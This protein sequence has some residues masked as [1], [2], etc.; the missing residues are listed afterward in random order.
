MGGNPVL[1]DRFEVI[2]HLGSGGVGKVYLV[3]DREAG[4]ERR[5]LK[6]VDLPPGRE[7]LYG[8]IRGEFEL[9][10]RFD[11]PHLA[12]AYDI[13]RMGSSAFFTLE[14][15][16]GPTFLEAVARLDTG[17][18]LRLAVE[19]LQA[20]A[21]IHG[22]GY[23]HGD[24]KPQNIMVDSRGE[25]PRAKLLDFGLAESIMEAKSPLL[26]SSGTPAY[27][28]PEK[29]QGAPPDPR[30]DLYS[31]GVTLFEVL[32]GTLPFGGRTPAELI[33]KHRN[34]PAPKP[35]GVDPGLG[36]ELDRI[37]LR[38]MEKEPRRRFQNA[39]AVI[40]ALAP[41]GPGASGSVQVQGGKHLVMAAFVGRE[42]DLESLE[43]ALNPPGAGRPSLR[44]FA[45]IGDEGMGKSTL[46]KELALTARVRGHRV[47]EQ[48]CSTGAQG[49][50]EI[51]EGL[52]LPLKAG[53]EDLDPLLGTSL[54]AWSQGERRAEGPRNDWDPTV[55]AKSLAGLF[56]ATSVR[57][58][59]LVVLQNLHEV[60][61]RF[62]S[63]LARLAREESD[64]HWAVVVAAREKF[65]DPR[66]GQ[67]FEPL[68]AGKDVRVVRLEP[69][70]AEDVT[71]WVS[72]AFPGVDLPAET[73]E[74][75]IRWSGGS[76]LLV[77]EALLTGVEE[78]RFAAG[79][80]GWRYV[81]PP[82][83]KRFPAAGG[84]VERRLKS[85]SEGEKEVL[86]ALALDTGELR[87]EWM[88][89][90]L[91]VEGPEV[92]FPLLRRLARS[93]WV[94]EDRSSRS[95]VLPNDRVKR[96]LL[97]EMGRMAREAGHRRFGEIIEVAGGEE[98]D[99]G[100][101]LAGH[102]ARSGDGDRG[103]RWCIRAGEWLEKRGRY[104]AALLH[105]RAARRLALARE[106]DS[107]EMNRI[108]IPLA[109][110]HLWR[111]N[112]K[113]AEKILRSCLERE[114]EAT[115]EAICRHRLAV[116]LMWRD[117]LEDALDMVRG[118]REILE[119][120]GERT[121]LGGVLDTLS[122]ILYRLGRFEEVIELSGKQLELV[123]ENPRAQVGI[124]LSTV[125]SMMAQGRLNEGV[126][127]VRRA[128][129]AARTLRDAPQLVAR[130]YS[131]FAAL[132]NN[133]AMSKRALRWHRAAARYYER[134]GFDLDA[135]NSRQSAGFLL[136]R[137]GVTTRASE[138]VSKALETFQRTGQVHAFASE[139]DWQILVAL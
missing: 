39:E 101:T 36:P 12:A 130:C 99:L 74:E 102:W 28:P 98:E 93:G 111:G 128:L 85:L 114:L 11:H 57:T 97:R 108:E 47:L 69:L 70:G 118:S 52:I 51:L 9:L 96:T 135:A 120:T 64:G 32:T 125:A 48:D 90:Y 78:G 132:R 131:S 3:D 14:Y 44:T 5:A 80:E 81:P 134:I 15:V 53:I 107:G 2:D 73:V 94:N 34:E 24:V 100:V 35:S 63:V 19:V 49:T 123:G 23:V 109:T 139:V 116:T 29:V 87:S 136:Y 30:S 86:R 115:Q 75:V 105:L 89:Q 76:P 22:L 1:F 41:F 62:M 38:L 119:E 124:W 79:K 133:Q 122:S 16:S 20:L 59:L 42:G 121:I 113:R 67:I 77:R 65:E 110:M 106:W 72:T 117:E 71:D 91:Q 21:F 4:G 84:Q 33:E 25:K 92:L 13:G 138:E 127:M 6:V 17:E 68:L 27:F 56:F 50:E 7:S 37:C 129:K 58:P 60:D 66:S 104:R 103:A 126:Q 45:V 46:L 43:D 31:F 55:L 40:S 112:P 61:S 88:S 10:A 82:R 83:G 26:A 54:G 95:F 18:M 137:M 8:L